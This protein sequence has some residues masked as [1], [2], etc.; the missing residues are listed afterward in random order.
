MLTP[1]PRGTSTFLALLLL[2][3]AAAAAHGA[4]AA[5]RNLLAN[6]GFEA[7]L[8]GHP[9]MPAAW[10][11]FSSGLP[12]VFFGRDTILVHGGRY[13]VSVA[14]LST[15]V[16]MFHNWS[17]TLVVGRE[18][19]GKDLV[20][21]VWTR[22]NGVQ[23]RAYVL[24]QAYRDTVTKMARIWGM[25]RDAARDRLG[26]T[27]TNDPL[28]N[29]GW[30]RRYFSENETRWVKRTVRIFVPPTTNVVIVRGGITGTGQV[31]FDD[32][33]L[34]AEPARPS[35]PVAPNTN[36]LADPGFEGDGNDWE[37]SMPPYEGLSVERDTTVA[38]SGRASIRMEGGLQGPVPARTG[39]CQMIANRN[40][41]GKRVRLSGWIK[42]DSLQTQAYIM[43]YCSTADGD[44]HEPTPVEFGMNTDWTLATM[45]VDVPPGT[46]I[47]WGW[48]LYN[49]PSRGRVWY[50]D[51]SLE[52]VGT[53][54]YVK[55][56]T[57][58]P[59]PLPLPSR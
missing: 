29:L 57:P 8:A 2:A 49:A 51:C 53:A 25:D 52:V 43:V 33:S 55:N 26:I 16:P 42:T 30:N 44:V 31:L 36:L 21:S 32:A 3:L 17:Q 6:P 14:S 48:F 45:E 50:D 37:Y 41:V 10:D 20:F 19:W 4:P 46:L 7:P 27:A 39:V 24:L 23:G 15:S 35:P 12:T 13:A 47:V 22:S 40:L 59:K 11:T 1:R 5:G 28:V 34:T 58:P 56:G 54:H 9:W 18:L 38:H